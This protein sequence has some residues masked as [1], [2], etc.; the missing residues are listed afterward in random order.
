MKVFVVIAC[1]NE[2]DEVPFIIGVSSERYLADGV[3]ADYEAHD[4]A[5]R[6]GNHPYQKYGYT[7]E[8][9]EWEVK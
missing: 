9:E 4:I 2:F 8:I 1:Y 6:E 3:V 7:Y 5:S